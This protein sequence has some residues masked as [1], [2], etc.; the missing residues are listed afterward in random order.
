LIRPTSSGGQ[1]HYE[2]LIRWRRDGVI[3][4]PAKLLPALERYGQAPIL[5]RWMLEAVISHLAAQPDDHAVYFIN[6]SG[7]TVADESFLGTICHLLDHYGVA[8][9]RIGFEVTET[10]RGGEPGRCPAPDRGSARTG[11]PVCTG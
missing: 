5:D 2:V 7:K 10:R 4:G 11:L 8:G 9:E 1:P 6:L 3:E